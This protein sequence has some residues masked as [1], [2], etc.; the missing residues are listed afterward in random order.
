M[1]LY[2]VD[3]AQKVSQDQPQIQKLFKTK[4]EKNF[5]R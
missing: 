1:I 4:I 5:F 3:Y 2:N